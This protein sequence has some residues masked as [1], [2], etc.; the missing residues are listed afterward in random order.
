[1]GGNLVISLPDT[2]ALIWWTLDPEKL[3]QM[4]VFLYKLN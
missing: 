1:M 3:S 2:G 4:T